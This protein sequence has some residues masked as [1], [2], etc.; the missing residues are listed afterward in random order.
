[1]TT[2]QSLAL[3]GATTAPVTFCV[4]AVDWLIRRWLSSQNR[5]ETWAIPTRLTARSRAAGSGRLVSAAMTA[6]MAS[7]HS[8]VTRST[9]SRTAA[10]S[11]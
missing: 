2:K 10:R 3:V 6:A 11:R 5:E 4:S 1:M 7:E 9:C 8:L